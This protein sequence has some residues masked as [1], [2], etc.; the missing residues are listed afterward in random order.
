MDGITRKPSDLTLDSIVV[1]KQMSSE[2]KDALE[3]IGERI[4]SS[5]EKENTNLLQAELKNAMLKIEGLENVVDKKV[6]DILAAVTSLAEK[7]DESN[8]HSVVAISDE[9]NDNPFLDDDP[10]LGFRNNNE[11]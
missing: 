2:K 4:E 1:D 6:A 5:K 11:E 8:S 10:L 9:M 7:V 3:A